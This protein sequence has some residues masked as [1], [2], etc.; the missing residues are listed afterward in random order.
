M[1]PGTDVQL[2]VWR[3]G[4]EQKVTVRT[5]LLEEQA[6]RPTGKATG[7]GSNEESRLGL[8]VRPLTPQEKQQVETDGVLVIEQANGPAAVAGVQP[9]D[10]ILGVNGKRVKT[11]AELRDASKSAGKTVA[12]LIQRQ[13]AQI[14]VPLRLN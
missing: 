11:L 7:S 1:K 10:I 6:T 2:S 12:L 4:R 3:G 8:T 13:D 14:F 9:G 5:D